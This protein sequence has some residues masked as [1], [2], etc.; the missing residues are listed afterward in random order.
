MDISVGVLQLFLMCLSMIGG[1]ALQTW[2]IIRYL[3][4]RMD[5]G[6]QRVHDRISEVKSNTVTQAEHDRDMER[7]HK[8]M[9]DLGQKVE[10]Q[11]NAT[12]ARLDTLIFA[13]TGGGNTPKK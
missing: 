4:S 7:L 5:S 1:I 2:G 3:I 6:D 10:Q 13:L 9:R 11:G 12:T 8:D